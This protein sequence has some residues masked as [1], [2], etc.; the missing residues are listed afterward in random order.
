MAV[1]A[2]VAVVAVV[3]VVVVAEEAEEAAAEAPALVLAPDS[4]S[5]T[6]WASEQASVPARGP[7]QALVTLHAAPALCVDPRQSQRPSAHHRCWEAPSD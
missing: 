4:G 5:A 7:A 1:M 2:V 6:A 3:V